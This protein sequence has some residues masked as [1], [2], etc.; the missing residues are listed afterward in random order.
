MI[1]NLHLIAGK[2]DVGNLDTQ[3]GKEVMKIFD[4]L[5]KDGHTIILVTHEKNI[6]AHA[7]RVIEVLDG[8]IVSDKT[9]K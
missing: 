6:A 7:N 8:E 3:S 5:N 9:R 2:L 1:K 4:G